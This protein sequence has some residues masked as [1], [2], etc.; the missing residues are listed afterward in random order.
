[1]QQTSIMP[2]RSKR[3]YIQFF[4]H[5]GKTKRK[6]IPHQE[7]CLSLIHAIHS[8]LFRLPNGDVFKTSDCNKSFEIKGKSMWR[9]V[10]LPSVAT[11]AAVH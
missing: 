7:T 2:I 10:L 8:F 5:K 4:C 9:I 1:M 3:R 11:V 6:H